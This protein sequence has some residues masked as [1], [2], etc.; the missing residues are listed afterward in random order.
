[1]LKIKINR[2]K[3]DK[4][5]G[6]LGDSKPLSSFDPEEVKKGIKVELEHTKDITIAKEIVSD[7]LSED[8]KYYTK[9]S[10]TGL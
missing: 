4:L 8:P 3:E 2:I 9:L 1:M 5:P 6:G 10:A 7:H